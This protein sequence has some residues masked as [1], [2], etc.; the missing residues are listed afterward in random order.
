LIRSRSISANQ[1]LDISNHQLD[2]PGTYPSNQPQT[3]LPV[4]LPVGRAVRVQYR[5][6]AR[7]A[8]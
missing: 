2:R 7:R 3:S 8:V 4:L 6:A 1:Q 5:I